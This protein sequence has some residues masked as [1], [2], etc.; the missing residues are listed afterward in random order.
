[1][2]A[3]CPPARLPAHPPDRPPTRSPACLPECLPASLT[4]TF[5]MKLP[6]PSMS[7]TGT[8]GLAAAAPSAEG[9]P[10]PMAPRPG[11][12]RRERGRRGGEGGEGLGGGNE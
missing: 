7:T 1:M 6:S 5:M 12:E 3:R 11:G 8:E 10:K 4:C 2:L 9:R